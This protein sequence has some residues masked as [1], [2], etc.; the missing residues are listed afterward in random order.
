MSGPPPLNEPLPGLVVGARLRLEMW[1]GEPDAVEA[2]RALIERS[3]P[4]LSQFLGWAVEPLDAAAEAAVQA[5]I[6]RRWREGRDAGWVIVEDGAPRGM[7]GLHRRGGPDELE[8]GYWLDDAATGRGLVT[9]ACRMAIDVAFGIEGIDVVEINHDAANLRSGAVPQRL[10]F[11]RIAAFTA[12]PAALLE[13]GIKVRWVVRRG[14]WL[15]RHESS[16]VLSTA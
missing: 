8:I 5:D 1:R 15:G 11:S 4:T 3:R 9:E 16:S 13:S 12:P 2:I 14:E 10:G 6:E 7:L